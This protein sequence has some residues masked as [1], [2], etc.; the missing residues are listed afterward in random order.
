MSD[1]NVVQSRGWMLQDD[2]LHRSSNDEH[3]TCAEE[4]GPHVLPYLTAKIVLIITMPWS[5]LS[6]FLPSLLF[7]QLLV[8]K[9]FRSFMHLSHVN[10]KLFFSL[11]LASP[12]ELS[13]YDVPTFSTHAIIIIAMYPPST[14][15]IKILCC[16]S[17]VAA[18][19][20]QRS[21]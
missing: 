21:V 6:T 18:Q 20:G 14:S 10:M 16:L 3:A 8:L 13:L 9:I 1:L 7:F 17:P 15:A 4:D 19:Y 5:S 2:W 11:P 12:V